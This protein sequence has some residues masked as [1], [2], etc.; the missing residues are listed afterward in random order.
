MPA[1]CWIK[2]TLPMDILQ[3]PSQKLFGSKSLHAQCWGQATD[4]ETQVQ[5][6]CR[7][8]NKKYLFYLQMNIY[9]YRYIY[10]YIS[11]Q[12]IIFHQPRFPWNPGMSLSQL[13]FGVRSYE[14]AIIWPDIFISRTSTTS[15]SWKFMIFAVFFF[16]VGQEFVFF[17]LGFLRFMQ[18]GFRIWA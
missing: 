8:Y 11:G 13:H 12:I 17:L 6:L 9:I 10:I 18:M 1:I 3:G 5:E 7:D 14:F 4:L 16:S 15:V 2:F